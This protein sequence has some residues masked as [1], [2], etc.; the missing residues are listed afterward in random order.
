MSDVRARLM[1]AEEEELT[2]VEK[3]ILFYRE[4]PVEAAKDLLDIDLIWYQRICLR[5]L[6]FKSY[7]LMNMGR[8]AGKT[9]MAMLYS[10]LR[11]MLF[12]KA[13]VGIIGPVYRQSQFVFDE[14]EGIWNNSA[15]LRACTP[16]GIKRGTANT[17]IKFEGNG[18]FI[19]A[20]P[21]GNDGG[22]VRGRR[23]TI[24]FVDEMAQVNEEIVRL[25]IRPMLNIKLS[26]RKNQFI[27]AS[28]AFYKYNHF[29]GNYCHYHVQAQEKPD[30]YSVL[31]YDYRDIMM[32][33]DSP[34][35]VDEEIIKMQYADMPLEQFNMECLS[36]FPDEG[37]GFFPAKLIAGCTPAGDSDKAVNLEL[38]GNRGSRY[39]MGVD[40]AREPGGDN[41]ALAVILIKGRELR[42]VHLLTLNGETFQN[43]VRTIRRKYKDF[44]VIK[45]CNDSGGGGGTLRDLLAEPWKDPEDP[46]AEMQLPILEVNPDDERYL[47]IE[48]LRVLEQ[49]KFTNESKNQMFND[50]KAE[51]HHRRFF[52]PTDIRRHEDPEIEYL[53]KEV[54]M[55]KTEMMAIQ[56][57]ATTQGL[58]FE[59]PKPYK[60]DR[61][62][63]VALAVKAALDLTREE[64]LAPPDMDMPTGFWLETSNYG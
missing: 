28:T 4:H 18:S 14:M 20:L 45:I 3:M 56:T 17:I 34:F 50:L 63:A 21:L 49:V 29:W 62:T 43:M 12:T 6:W 39:V 9:F 23:Y 16:A 57:S 44:N 59:A 24:A 51:M 38:T 52:M 46:K 26:G 61:V 1:K 33:P 7:I 31:E 13:R 37:T 19:E 36:I 32:V 54:S 47:E 15:Y 64:F 8:G 42:L 48:G 58:K 30:Q 53:G 25:V 55:T 60:M 40:C 11:C 22:K 10:V 5:E 41:F 27:Q 35:Q 2:D